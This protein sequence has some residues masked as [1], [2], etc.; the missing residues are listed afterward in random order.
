MKIIKI[1]GGLGN[2]MFQYSFFKYLLNNNIP[3]KID[4]SDFEKY[5]LHNGLEL[6]KIFNVLKPEYIATTTEISLCKDIQPLF[7]LRK[8]FGNLFLNNKSALIRKSH[9][10]EPN[11]CHYYNVI[12]ETDADYLEGYWQNENYLNPIRELLIKDFQWNSIDYRNLQ[13]VNSLINENSVS[14]HVRRLD[15]TK[16]F[17]QLFYLLKLKMVWRIA[18]KNYY[19]N[20]IEYINEHVENPKFYIFTDNVEWVKTNLSISTNFELVDWNRKDK[21]NEDLFLMSKCKHNII[22]MSSFSWWGAWLNNYEQKIVV[23]PKKWALRFNKSN[24]IIPPTW[25]RL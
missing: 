21:S 3:A 7:K 19:Q 24:E 4:I 20:A 6:D 5:G 9:W 15:S 17:R 2:Q 25:K 13:L 14:L 11:F 12:I 8:L 22:S 1:L 10:I 23:A 18:D 16:S